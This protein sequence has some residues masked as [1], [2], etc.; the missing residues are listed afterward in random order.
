MRVD[1]HSET[2]DY[3]QAIADYSQAIRLKPDYAKAYD[4][5]GNAYSRLGRFDPAFADFRQ[6]G[7][8]PVRAIVLLC[9]MPAMTVLLGL[10]A[11]R[12]VRQRLLL[13]RRRAINT[14]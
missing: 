2:Q 7:A 4:N 10:A 13:N 8:N 5:R 12:F 11:M 6:G 1:S 14:Q 3:D 9:G